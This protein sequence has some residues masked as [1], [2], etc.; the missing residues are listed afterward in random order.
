MRGSGGEMVR[1]GVPS[2]W[3]GSSIPVHVIL[4]KDGISKT[5]GVFSK[6][7]ILNVLLMFFRGKHRVI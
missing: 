5:D 1:I 2:D 4:E 7:N 3:V 6:E